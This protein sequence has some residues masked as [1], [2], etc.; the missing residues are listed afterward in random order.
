MKNRPLEVSIIFGKEAGAC[1]A[2]CGTDWSLPENIAAA[3]NDV[4]SKF[5][6]RVALSFCNLSFSSDC[7]V[8]EDLSRL[9]AAGSIMLPLLV[10]EGE[11]R[12]TGYFDLRMMR[13]VIEAEMERRDG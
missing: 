6:P 13:D 9:I 5:G 3:R 1:D 10:I 7:R 12:I 8:P 11:A 4:S 2:G